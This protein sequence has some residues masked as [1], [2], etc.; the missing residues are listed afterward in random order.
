MSRLHQLIKDDPRY[1]K[2]RRDCFIRDGYRCV[3]CG[4]GDRLEADHIIPLVAGG[5]PFDLDNLATRCK[6]CNLR[7]GTDVPMVRQRWVNP[8][9]PELSQPAELDLVFLT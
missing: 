9:Y 5:D 3:D 8:A 6:P 1:L 4:S 7:K 2:A